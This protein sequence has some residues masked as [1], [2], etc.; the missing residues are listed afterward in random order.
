MKVKDILE[1]VK[2]NELSIEEASELI[3]NPLDYATIDFNREKRTGASEVIYGAG[4]TK[5]HIAGIIQNMLDHEVPNI[6][7]TRLD[8]AKYDY[9]K[10]LYPEFVYD[11]LAQTFLLNQTPK[12]KNKG[13]IVVACA[14]TSD[15]PVAKEAV[16][17]AKY[18]GNDVELITD[19]GV[20]GIHRL[21]NRLDVIEKA[22]VIIAIAGM[23][24]ALASV[25][26]G[27]TD[28]PVIAVPTS[29]GYGANFNGLAA[30]L[31]MLNSC[32][33]GISVV[34][35]DNGFGAGFMA[36]TINNLGGKKE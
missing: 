8:E 1:K 31:A 10:K 28:K 9:L 14:G 19:V 29:V 17:T 3:D 30:L 13:L 26:G 12:P 25:I 6:L 18:L 7:V 33:S 2:K 21:F 11:E 24:G 15:L 36:H 23:E 35:I 20:A 34:N 4:K 5:E 27:L 22:S 32:A 16:I